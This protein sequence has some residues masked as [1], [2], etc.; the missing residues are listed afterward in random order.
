VTKNNEI[1]VMIRRINDANQ[2]I[3]SRQLLLP[4]GA[5]RY[6]RCPSRIKASRRGVVSRADTANATARTVIVTTP[7][8]AMMRKEK[9]ELI[10]LRVVP[11]PTRGFESVR[12]KSGTALM[13]L[14][15]ID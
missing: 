13:L 10:R 5:A 12:G 4:S 7:M 6:S 8:M 9:P 2:M 11:V 1:H 15:L 3:F 14:K